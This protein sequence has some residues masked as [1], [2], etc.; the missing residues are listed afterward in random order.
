MSEEYDYLKRALQKRER[1]YYEEHPQRS[2]NLTPTEWT[3]PYGMPVYKDQHGQHHSESS[4]TFRTPGPEGKWTTAPVIWP[5]PETG[6]ARYFEE[7][8]LI[9]ILGSNGWRNPITGEKLPMFDTEPEATSWAVDRDMT[10]QD[11]NLPYN[12]GEVN[13]RGY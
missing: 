1:K 6:E 3:S 9:E 4:A 11:K 12:Q 13:E 5:D 2:L 8:E 7:D 10:L